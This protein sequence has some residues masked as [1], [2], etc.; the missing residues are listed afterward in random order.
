LG[1]SDP[2]STP[3][4]FGNGTRGFADFF[5]STPVPVT[6]GTT[7]FFQPVVVSGDLL[8]LADDIYRYSGGEAFASG[9]AFP[10]A[11]F[12]FREGLVVPEPS[13]WALL[14]LGGG[15]LGWRWRSRQK[16]PGGKSSSP[17]PT[18]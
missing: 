4:G 10:N 2:V 15:M 13:T 6:P 8:D 7:Y 16:N 14:L 17:P 18:P 9:V 12:W 5:F 3:D 11:D 1:T